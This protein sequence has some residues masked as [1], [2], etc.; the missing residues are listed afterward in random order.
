MSDAKVHD[1][2][3][4]LTYRIHADLRAYIPPR[5]KV[6][7]NLALWP[8]CNRVAINLIGWGFLTNEALTYI[9][10]NLR[11]TT[12][13]LAINVGSCVSEKR[14][15]VMMPGVVFTFT[16]TNDEGYTILTGPIAQIDNVDAVTAVQTTTAT[17]LL[18]IWPRDEFLALALKAA[19][20]NKHITKIVFCDEECAGGFA[21]DAFLEE[22]KANWHIIG[23]NAPQS[24]RTEYSGGHKGHTYLTLIFILVRSEST[25]VVENFRELHFFPERTSNVH[26]GTDLEF[27]EQLRQIVMALDVLD[28]E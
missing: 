26:L 18:T 23:S 1:V 7:A 24:P 10:D 21:L 25:D 19:H 13:V 16:D 3:M 11:G 5:V 12:N 28:A 27:N 14:L 22:H 15:S 8:I 17:V 2:Y 6:P 20:E 9:A 4:R